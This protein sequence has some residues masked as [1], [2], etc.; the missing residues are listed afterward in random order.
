MFSST[1][2]PGRHHRSVL[3]EAIL[4]R[5]L[6]R[7]EG[8]VLYW[9]RTL[10]IL[11]R[12]M[13]HHAVLTQRPPCPVVGGRRRATLCPSL[14]ASA[15]LSDSPHLVG[16]VIVV[17]HHDDRADRRRRRRSHPSVVVVVPLY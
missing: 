7:T 4:G 8:I 2:I 17:N 5:L 13:E 12:T 1:S 16:H 6:S 11:M 3:R 14:D 15:Y 9:S 10:L